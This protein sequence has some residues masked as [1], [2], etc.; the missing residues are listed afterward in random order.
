MGKRRKTILVAC[1]GAVATS[2]VAA[3]KIKDLCNKAG[4]PADVI[5]C[6]I[7]ELD[8]NSERADIIVTTSKVTK[9]FGKPLISGIPF[10]SGIGIE[11]V[12]K[13]IIKAL[14]EEEV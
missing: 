14:K 9:N 2:T 12:E 3:Q 8:A 1:A 7:S 4:I 5:Q 11:E 10:I 13:Q 6:R